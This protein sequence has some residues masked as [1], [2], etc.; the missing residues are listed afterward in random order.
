MRYTAVYCKDVDKDGEIE[1]PTELQLPTYQ[2]NGVDE[3]LYLIQWNSYDGQVLR[4]ISQS[5]VN[6]NENFSV[7]IPEDW[8]GKL[9][10]ERPEDNDRAFLFK[11]RKGELLFTIR[12]YGL[13][14]FSEDLVDKGWRKL[15]ADSDRVYTVYCE[16]GNSFDISYTQIYGIFEAIS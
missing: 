5:F 2:R 13:T 3:N 9:T 8:E 12:V 6:V 16:K 4:P 1:V 10:V 15:Y 11:S 7:A 14:E